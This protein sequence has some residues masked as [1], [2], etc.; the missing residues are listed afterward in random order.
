MRVNNSINPFM[1]K[2]PPALLTHDK[3][4][5]TFKDIKSL[6][7]ISKMVENCGVINM[8]YLSC[9]NMF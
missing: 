4:G 3:Y 9:T 5:I 8:F 7:S 2:A 1:F 6:L